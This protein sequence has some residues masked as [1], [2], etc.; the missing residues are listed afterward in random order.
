MIAGCMRPST[1]FESRENKLELEDKAEQNLV[2][3]LIVTEESKA[4]FQ[5]QFEAAGYKTLAISL[6]RA[7][8]AINEFHP[9]VVLLEAA[10]TNVAASEGLALARQLRSNPA[11]YVLP[12]VLVCDELNAAL[13]ATAASIGLDDCFVR[14]TPFTEVLVRLDAL[15]WRVE[16]GRRMPGL[17]GDQRLEIDNLLLLSDAVRHEIGR[18][19]SGSVALVNLGSA[20]PQQSERGIERYRRTALGFFKLNLRRMDA[21]AFYGPAVLV[22]SLPGMSVA[23]ASSA[24]LG[25]QEQFVETNPGGELKVGLASFPADGTDLERLLAVCEARMTSALLNEPETRF[26][27]EQP[28]EP[29]S[30]L[31]EEVI[32]QTSRTVDAD[33]SMLSPEPIAWLEVESAAK[34]FSRAGSVLLAISDRPRMARLNSLIRSAGYEV[35][36]AF[37]GEQTLNLLRIERPDLLML[38][39][40]LD[41][42]S[43]LEMIK[44]LRKQ[45]GGRLIPSVLFL[46]SS[47]DEAAGLEALALGARKVL[48]HPYD[49]ADVLA[50]VRELETTEVK[51]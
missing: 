26:V 38:E 33:F 29:A 14:S 11:T 48:T 34:E 24:L 35:R 37:D 19:R 2:R 12:V 32:S 36:A 15:L 30:L 13:R 43:G 50:G 16:A 4:A 47:D 49:P 6:T 10:G 44:R 41:K 27:V 25:L 21:V 51:S 22:I 46:N 7:E 23:A 31:D 42:I 5:M 8:H 17:I 40:E 39:S 9:D 45:N 1:Q 3:V 18:G 28:P 20:L